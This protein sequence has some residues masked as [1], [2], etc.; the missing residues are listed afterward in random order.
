VCEVNA[1]LVLLSERNV[2]SLLV[3]SNTEAVQLLLD[4]VLVRQRFQRVETDQNQIA[5]LCRRNDLSTTTF[6]ILGTFNNAYTQPFFVTLE[7]FHKTKQLTRQ[8]E[9]LH[10]RVL[11]VKGAKKKKKNQTTHVSLPE[12]SLLCNR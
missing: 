10:K 5:R 2:R 9:H 7:T 3:Q 6:T 4:H 8:I 12:F 11:Y 1:A